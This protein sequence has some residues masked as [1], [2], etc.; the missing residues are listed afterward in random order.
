MKGLRLIIGGL[1]M[2][3]TLLWSLQ[4]DAQPGLPFITHYKLPGSMSTQ[5]WAIEQGKNNL[6]YFLNR[7][8]V[9]S[10]D[11]YEWENLQVDGRPLA[12]AFHEKLYVSTDRGIVSFERDRKGE[13]VQ[14]EVKDTIYDYYHKLVSVGNTLYAIGTQNVCKLIGGESPFLQNIYAETDSTHFITDAFNFKDELYIVQNKI[15]VFLIRNG[16]AVPLK[17]SLPEGTEI[18]F[19]FGNGTDLYLG[20]SNNCIYRFNGKDLSPFVIKDQAYLDASYLN[21]GIVVDKSRIALATLLGGCVVVDSKNGETLALVNYRAGLPDDEVYSLGVDHYSGLWLAH[22]MGISRIDFSIPV[23]SY[24]HYSGLS[25]NVLSVVDFQNHLYVGTSEGL[26][27]LD[28]VK[29]YKE[30]EVNVKERVA[31]RQ[32]K[33]TESE[34]KAD[35]ATVNEHEKKR[36]SFFSRLFDKISGSKAAEEKTEVL[37][38]KKQAQSSREYMIRKRKVLTLQSVGYAYRKIANLEGK[39]RQLVAFNNEL[40]VVSSRGIYSVTGDKAKAIISGTYTLF[41]LPSGFNKDLVWIGTE[42]GLVEIAKNDGSWT[43][44][45][46]FPTE[47]DLP[48]SVAELSAKE[49][50]LTTEST[51]IK[52]TLNGASVANSAVVSAKGG[53]FDS[54]VARTIMGR[55]MI[56]T[57]N[58]VYL[59]DKNSNTLSDDSLQFA[60]SDIKVL[61]TQGKVTWLKLKG[62]WKC[63]SPRG[64]IENPNLPFLALFDKINDIFLTTGNTLYLVNGYN[65]ILRIVNPEKPIDSVGFSLLVKKVKDGNGDL[66][67][68]DNI[69]LNYSNNALRITIAAP[70]FMKEKSA[71]FQYQIEGMMNH[72]SEW[73]RTPVLE[74]PF[75]PSGHY[76]LKIR[77]RDVLGHQSKEYDLSFRVRPPFWKSIWFISLST[78]LLLFVLVI[79]IRVRERNLIRDKIVLEQKVRMRTQTIEEQRLE[80][81]NQRDAL[82]QQNEE[83]MQQKEEIETQ[84]DEIENQRDQIVKQNENI[85]K[86]IEYAKRIQTAAMPS[87]EVVEAIL[88][89]HFILFKPRDIVSGDFYWTVDHNGKTIVA[90]ADCTGHGVPGA[91]MSMLGL[92]FLSEIVNTVGDLHPATILNELRTFIKY[93]LS[94]E[95]SESESKDGMDIALCVIDHDSG[96]LEFAGAYNPIY[97]I[98]NGVIEEIKGDKMPVGIHPG[99]KA[100]FTNNVIPLEGITAFYL[101]SDG[102]ADQFGGSEG[103]K[104]KSKNFRELIAKNHA[105]PMSE[106][107]LVLDAAFSKWQ[108]YNDQVDDVLVVGVRIV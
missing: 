20:L 43:T 108:G 12:M 14:K 61:F 64:P 49:L 57:A 90:V 94:Q 11:G 32:E 84:R 54:P 82:A 34:S 70:S 42:K 38:N 99:E 77:A 48:V 45:T 86:S 76:K 39:C 1:S 5:T 101:F 13:F 41:A 26:Y 60:S 9:F 65:E 17:L 8:G 53:A 100:S 85:T 106:Q 35:E 36:K 51:V 63:Y 97:I 7:K 2:A 98:R 3:A 15:Q 59:Y 46:I 107:R 55:P 56:I 24:E 33:V 28:E 25:G 52:L 47:N 93:T 40:L 89:E 103:R 21:G 83:I 6:V 29:G 18:N 105:L 37:T 66:L 58:R 91:F 72:W 95:G 23:T 74:F 44:T 50:L 87:K 62:E 75:F 69:D 4:A 67:N 73:S 104:F 10:F 92:S 71:E 68:L 96:Q 81:E 31:R 27:L 30:V 19:T 78:I 80:M 88:P 16:R 79:F 22:G 102:F